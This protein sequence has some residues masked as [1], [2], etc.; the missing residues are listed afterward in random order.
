MVNKRICFPPFKT[1][2]CQCRVI[3]KTYLRLEVDCRERRA[4]FTSLPQEREVGERV[5]KPNKQSTQFSRVHAI[6]RENKERLAKVLLACLVI[7][8]NYAG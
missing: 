7:G 8:A 3:I 2:I 4:G 1:K 5:A 6:E